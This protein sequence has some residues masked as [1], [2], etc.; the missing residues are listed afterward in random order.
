MAGNIV[1]PFEPLPEQPTLSINEA[2]AQLIESGKSLR[3]QQQDLN[4]AYINELI[5]RNPEQEDLPLPVNGNYKQ[6]ELQ[7]L[8]DIIGFRPQTKEQVLQYLDNNPLLSKLYENDEGYKNAIAD[9]VLRR[10]LELSNG[11]EPTYNELLGDVDP[12]TQI[13]YSN[14]GENPDSRFM[15]V[16]KN[17]ILKPIDSFLHTDFMDSNK[18]LRA[19]V[20]SME[21]LSAFGKDTQTAVGKLRTLG[22]LKRQANELAKRV[23]PFTEEGRQAELDLEAVQAKINSLALTDAE[24]AAYQKNGEAYL[25][26]EARYNSIKSWEKDVNPRYIEDVQNDIE[27][28]EFNQYMNLKY[29]NNSVTS[30]FKNMDYIKD[31]MGHE[32]NKVFGSKAKFINSLEELAPWMALSL[33]TGA[34]GPWGK[35]IQAAL[36]G[37]S[38]TANI[39]TALD[40]Y[41]QKYGTVEGFNK[42]Q[43]FVGGGLN[44]LAN[45]YGGHVTLR[46]IPSSTVNAIKGAINEEYGKTSAIIQKALNNVSDA[47]IANSMV[48]AG[49]KNFSTFTLPSIVSRVGRNLESYGSKVSLNATKL[50]AEEATTKV[51]KIAETLA[52]PKKTAGKLIS[53]VGKALDSAVSK[54]VAGLVQGSIGGG[55]SMALDNLTAEF[56]TQLGNQTGYDAD[57]ALQS[58]LEGIPVG[59]A[60]H[61]GGLGAN[62]VGRIGLNAKN[63]L[64]D[65]WKPLHKYRL[66]N[67][68]MAIEDKILSNK[69]FIG[70]EASINYLKERTTDLTNA[71][72]D[73]TKVEKEN[74]FAVNATSTNS[75]EQKE[76]NKSRKKYTEAVQL[77]ADLDTR[78]KYLKNL[79]DKSIK[80]YGENAKTTAEQVKAAAY[81]QT[82]MSEEFAKEQYSNETV[83]KAKVEQAEALREEK[84]YTN[85]FGDEKLLKTL[86]HWLTI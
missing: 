83:Q 42:L 8:K 48:K 52:S 66:S 28:A 46:G 64:Y 27:E 74:E 51:G 37:I 36:T 86:I 70:T 24:V 43:A 49:L 29:G 76:I 55:A 20:D 15:Q 60:G 65:R 12:R 40:A 47:S 26:E 44:Y 54:T 25:Q 58:A 78:L 38:A 17:D 63:A 81:A 34:T 3:Q 39:D 50:G 14:Q 16:V 9:S 35:V 19:K 6:A 77:K 11:Q 18:A 2:S 62:V 30:N 33:I 82:N 80:L 23:T 45:M 22:E 4:R 59:M 5:K 72:K 84:E 73:V 21:K 31:I 71:I 67:K 85:D 75:A 57:K 61:L 13:D 32:F 56:A 79:K 41:F 69:D 53:G 10:S 68:D 1:N 7:L